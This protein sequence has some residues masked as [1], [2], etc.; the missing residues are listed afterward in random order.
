MTNQFDT[1]KSLT[2]SMISPQ[3]HRG[4]SCGLG[5]L[6]QAPKKGLPVRCHFRVTRESISNVLS[7]SPQREWGCLKKVMV[8]LNGGSKR[9]FSTLVVEKVHKLSLVLP[10]L[11]KQ[12][13]LGSIVCG[14]GIY[15]IYFLYYSNGN[16]SISPQTLKTILYKKIISLIYTQRH[17]IRI[18][19]LK[20]LG[21]LN[22]DVVAF[23]LKYQPFLKMIMRFLF[24]YL[25][26]PVIPFFF[27]WKP[28]IAHCMENTAM[29]EGMGEGIEEDRGKAEKRT[30]LRELFRREIYGKQFS[31]QKLLRNDVREPT[32]TPIERQV[33]NFSQVPDEDARYYLLESWN[34]IETR[35][36]NREFAQGDY[37][38]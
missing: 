16:K 9:G 17:F 38:V 7:F 35:V 14:F 33:Q 32:P 12:L 15:L 34:D 31:C 30:I 19:P 29:V 8:N 37:G 21:L 26:I 13:L 22:T 4:V 1:K 11:E 27:F 5:Y 25:G 6:K 10:Y 20:T 36:F 24:L 3:G 28:Q 18:K 2:L 23:L